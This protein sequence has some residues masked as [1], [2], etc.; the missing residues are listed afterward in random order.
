MA[1]NPKQAA[2]WTPGSTQALVQLA[3]FDDGVVAQASSCVDGAEK[4]KLWDDLATEL[5]HE[6]GTS[7]TSTQCQNK[8]KNLSSKYRTERAKV[9][10]SGRPA[11]TWSL[12]DLM[13]QATVHFPSYNFSAGSQVDTGAGEPTPAPA[14]LVPTMADA[15]QRA[16]NPATATPLQVPPI[17]AGAP[18]QGMAPPA[19]TPGAPAAPAPGA[20]PAPPSAPAAPPAMAAVPQAPPLP[21][22]APQGEMAPPAA[23]PAPPAAPA[24]GQPPVASGEGLLNSSQEEDS[25]LDSSVSSVE[26]AD[27]P[28]VTPVTVRAPRVLPGSKKNAR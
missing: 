22:A 15:R 2:R 8:W 5:N 4:A 28:V 6:C 1:T 3:G 11:S 7:Y 23:P 19:A 9:T 14:P 25:A 27:L 20:T 12:F 18:Q 10:P 26:E 16:A 21:A 17:P 13:Q 24:P